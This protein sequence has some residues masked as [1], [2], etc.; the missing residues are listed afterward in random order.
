[1]KKVLFID[2]LCPKGHIGFNNI[3]IDALESN[4]EISL[5]LAFSK[6]YFKNL[7]YNNINKCITIPD[8]LFKTSKGIFQSFLN[9]IYRYTIQKYIIR[10]IHLQTYDF[11]L[12]SSFETLTIPLTKFPKNTFFI[13]HINIELASKNHIFLIA[14]RKIA[15]QYKLIV[16]N[17]EIKSF[18]NSKNIFNCDIIPHGLRV[19]FKISQIKKDVFSYQ[20]KIMFLPS[21]TSSDKDLINDLLSLDKFNEILKKNNIRLILR[22]H[23]LK[24]QKSNITIYKKY[25]STEEYQG[26]F[27]RSDYIFLPYSFK[28]KHR[29][30]AILYEAISNN[31]KL[32]VRDISAFKEVREN[33]TGAIFFNDF[34][35][36]YRKLKNSLLN[37][38]ELDYSKFKKL[39]SPQEIVNRLFDI[40]Y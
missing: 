31:K 13:C 23:K 18:L 4:K 22:N 27:L 11:V 9:R 12:V 1:M 19:P 34:D 28:F 33:I 3:Y 5:D 32:I 2:F 40:K 8:N 38:I 37:D 35:D 16:F 7:E 39:N 10:N 21:Y 14:L 24:S 30:S 20:E 26:L 15:K 36:L 29:I 6:S 17:K 25:L